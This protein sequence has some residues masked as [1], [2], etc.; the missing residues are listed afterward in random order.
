MGLHDA[1]TGLDP[2]APRRYWVPRTQLGRWGL[3]LGVLGAVLMPA[4]MLF[5]PLGAFPQLGLMA[6]GGAC[7]LV[8]IVRRGERAMLAFLGLL[9]LLFVLVFLVGEFAFPH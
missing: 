1:E 3:G 5:G 8:A 6:V 7:A 2:P 4:W 9:P